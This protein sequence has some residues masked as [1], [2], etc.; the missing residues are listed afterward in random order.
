MECEVSFAKPPIMVNEEVA[1]L[2]SSPEFYDEDTGQVSFAAF[3]L[4]TFANGEEE[5]Y[6]SLSRL[7]YTDNRH[8]KKKGKYVFK[9][10]TSDYVGYGI[11][12]VQDVLK[13]AFV[14]VFPVRNGAVEHCGLFYINERHEVLKGNL[15][16]YPEVFDSIYG[17]C[18]LSEKKLVLMEK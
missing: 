9:K 1:R 10:T 6:I 3:N 4:R 2:L 8:L 14:R 5:S 13:D 11:L 18:E 16:S 12:H 7:S 17:L 15:S